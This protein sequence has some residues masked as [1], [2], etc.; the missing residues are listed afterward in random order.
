MGYWGKASHPV[1]LYKARYNITR[2]FLPGGNSFVARVP[3]PI[4]VSLEW[5]CASP[6]REWLTRL[7]F[8][9]APFNPKPPPLVTQR[10]QNY[11]CYT[12]G[13]ISLY[14]EYPQFSCNR[15]HACTAVRA[16]LDRSQAH[17]EGGVG[18]SGSRRRKK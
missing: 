3:P 5:R 10:N 16:G 17:N 15:C 4:K 2:A 13:P 1:G 6:K 14:R 8:Q 9:N 12:I 7:V 11:R 18:G